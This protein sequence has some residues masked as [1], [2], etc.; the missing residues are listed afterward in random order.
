MRAILVAL[1]LVGGCYDG[2]AY[3]TMAPVTLGCGGNSD[4]RRGGICVQGLC[5][6]NPLPYSCVPDVGG[7]GCEHGRCCP[8]DVNQ[9]CGGST[10]QAGDPVMAC[11]ENTCVACGE[12]TGPCCP[13][14][15]QCGFGLKC[16]DGICYPATIA[17]K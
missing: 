1:M 10:W 8:G 4:C 9:P 15:A 12:P 7:C 13:S 6:G 11:V 5:T 17:A 2:G 16:T 3:P 14:L